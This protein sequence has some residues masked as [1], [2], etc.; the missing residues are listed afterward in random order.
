[1]SPVLYIV[2]EDLA[3]VALTIVERML[4]TVSEVKVSRAHNLFYRGSS[5]R[6]DFL[7]ARQVNSKVHTG[8]TNDHTD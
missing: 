2:V 5:K 8:T 4:I 3:L 6:G 1:M 7:A